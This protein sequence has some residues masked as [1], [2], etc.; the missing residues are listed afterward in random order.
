MRS[1][2]RHALAPLLVP[3]VFL[4][5]QVAGGAPHTTFPDTTRYARAAEQHAGHGRDEAQATAVRY[6]CAQRARAEGREAALDALPPDLGDVVAKSEAACLRRFGGLA[7]VTT[8]DARYQSIFTSRWAYPWT[9]V[10]FTATLGLADGL[11]VHGLLVTGGCALLAFG[12]LR[13]AGLGRRAAMAGQVALLATP[14]GWWSLQPLTEGL[15]L[16]CVLGSVWG[17]V[18]LLRT[19]GN[20]PS[21]LPYAALLAGSLVACFLVRYSTSLLLS[22]AVAAAGALIALVRRRGA[23]APVGGALWVTAVAGVATL[24]GAGAIAAL[25]LPSSTVTLQD[26]FTKHFRLPLV[27]DPWPR[28]WDLNWA[29]WSHWWG[30][31]VTQPYFLALTAAACWALWHRARELGLLCAL[32]ALLGAAQVAAHPLV[33]EAERLG[34]LMWLPVALGLPFLPGAWVERARAKATMEADR[35]RTEDTVRASEPLNSR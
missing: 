35:A 11:R 25:G 9:L 21:P 5:L 29:Y 34:V 26:T 8:T 24:A 3:V 31:Q 22:G 20:K 15:T 16:A 33:G 23:I 18:G 27:P 6:F 1:A 28:L 7:D 14:L 12:L 2:W 10:P 32:I 17:A 30:E 13:C 19:K 4:V